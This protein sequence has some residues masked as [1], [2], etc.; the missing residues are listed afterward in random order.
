MYVLLSCRE[1][2]VWGDTGQWIFLT[3]IFKAMT[4]INWHLTQAHNKMDC[5]V[6]LKIHCQH[7]TIGI[8]CSQF[9]ITKKMVV[10]NYF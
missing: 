7:F 5:T 10:H 1:R 4:E 3:L 9:I 2:T 6:S 8:T